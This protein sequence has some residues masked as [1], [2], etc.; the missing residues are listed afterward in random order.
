[1]GYEVVAWERDELYYLLLGLATT[2]SELSKLKEELATKDLE[3]YVKVWE[4]AEYELDLD[5]KDM[6][7]L[8]SFISLW[9]SSVENIAENNEFQEEDWNRLISSDNDVSD[10]LKSMM[11]EVDVVFNES[12][13]DSI[14]EQR[15]I[16]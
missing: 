16:L 12:G 15:Y 3:A 4:T 6:D 5:T 2:E 9:K 13:Q 11:N 8:N 1:E 10:Q 7:W 14:T